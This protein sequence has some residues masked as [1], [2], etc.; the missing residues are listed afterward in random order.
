[1]APPRGRRRKPD[2]KPEDEP[3][4]KAK[5]TPPTLRLAAL[6]L[7]ILILGV[8]LQNRLSSP[9]TT[10]SSAPTGTRVATL[11]YHPPG[12]RSFD[13]ACALTRRAIS[14]GL[15][16]TL[17]DVLGVDADAG[18][19]EIRAAYT[20]ASDGVPCSGTRDG[21]CERRILLGRLCRLLLAGEERRVY[22]E[23]LASVGEEMG[24]PRGGSGTK[25]AV[26]RV[27][28]R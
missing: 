14:L 5:P 2:P 27:C 9:A 19:D 20:R 4:A 10:T 6:L 17:Y 18:A 22:D 16:P 24:N 15:G 3:D 8:G 7:F 13:E 23:F 11:A 1:M 25:G 26:G 21:E 12:N 28:G